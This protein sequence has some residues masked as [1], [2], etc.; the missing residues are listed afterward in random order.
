MAYGE[1][2]GHVTSMTSRD[3]YSGISRKW[4]DWRLTLGSKAYQRTTNR[5]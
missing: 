3:P 4:L 1:S 5:K 2:N